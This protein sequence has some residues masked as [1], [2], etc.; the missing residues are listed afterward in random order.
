MTRH[1]LGVSSKGPNVFRNVRRD[2]TGEPLL[3]LDQDEV[4]RLTI[5]CSDWLETEETISSVS[6]T[7]RNATISVSTSGDRAIITIANVTSF[8]DGDITVIA[9]ASTGEKWRGKIRVRRT[10]RENDE[11]LFFSDYR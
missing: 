2:V 4:A 8:H 3:L 10:N 7:A 6:A 9:T 5:D 11:A 1:Y